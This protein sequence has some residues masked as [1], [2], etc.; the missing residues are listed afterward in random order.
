[1]MI[2]RII[3]EENQYNPASQMFVLGAE[4]IQEIRSLRETNSCV[5]IFA[6]PAL[7]DAI[8][9]KQLAEREARENALLA[10]DLDRQLEIALRDAG[11]KKALIP[12]ATRGLCDEFAWDENTGDF[13]VCDKDDKFVPSPTGSG[14][15]TVEELVTEFAAKPENA[16]FFGT[17]K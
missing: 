16:D 2:V 10:R 3:L 13:Y 9:R 17:A 5:E 6:R 8:L 11:A 1:M 15:K 4:A 14:Y 12:G 7:G